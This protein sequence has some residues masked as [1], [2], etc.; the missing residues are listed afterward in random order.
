MKE[1]CARLTALLAEI[2][3]VYR[4]IL[5]LSQRKKDTLIAGQVKEL[6]EITRQEETLILQVGRLEKERQQVM[7][8]IRQVNGLQDEE[9]TLV[10]VKDLVDASTAGR[11]ETGSEELRSVLRDLKSMN[12]L[13][14][15]LLQRAIAFVDFNINVLAQHSVGPVYAAQGQNGTSVQERT[16]VDRK[17]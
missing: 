7:A 8:E 16:L 17:A 11:L 2:L 5:T 3:E 15:K 1:L 10:Q 14:T 6:E 13:N 12:E 4:T 9:L